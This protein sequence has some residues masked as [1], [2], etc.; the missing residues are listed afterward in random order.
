MKK[1]FLLSVLRIL[2]PANDGT[3]KAL[4]AGCAGSR[5]E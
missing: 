5:G 2:H 1:L 3:N 4:L